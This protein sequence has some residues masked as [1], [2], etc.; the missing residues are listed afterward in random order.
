[1]KNAFFLIPVLFVAAFML[2]GPFSSEN[3]SDAPVVLTHADP[4][5]ILML[6]TQSC[7]Y[8]KVAR[9]F[10]SSHKLPYVEHDIEVSDKHLQMFYLLGGKGTPLLIING[11]VIHGWDEQAVRDAL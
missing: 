2:V 6:G 10:F 9:S 4:P 7:R 1:M 8:C 5:N 3:L 11:Q